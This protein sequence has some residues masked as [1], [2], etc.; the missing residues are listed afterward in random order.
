MLT[1]NNRC[2]SKFTSLLNNHIKEVLIL[3]SLTHLSAVHM[4]LAM[5]DNI[6][7]TIPDNS[8]MDKI[9]N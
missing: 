4:H 5:K 1:T 9:S 8:Q 7:N 3:K 6:I 2:C